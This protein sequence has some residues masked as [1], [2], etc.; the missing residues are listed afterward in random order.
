[1][2]GAERVLHIRYDTFY[3]HTL[4]AKSFFVPKKVYCRLAL[5][6][7]A[8]DH[9]NL[10][11]G[12]RTVFIESSLVLGDST[13]SNGSHLWERVKVVHFMIGFGTIFS[14]PVRS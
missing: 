6:S 4:P 3:V 10:F 1:M 13:R 7:L 12:K 9:D 11:F 8:Q 2:Y 14:V 5:F